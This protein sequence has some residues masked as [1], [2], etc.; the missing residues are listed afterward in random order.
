MI[1]RNPNQRV[2]VLVDVQNLH[3][4]AKN[5]FKAKISFEN[6]LKLAVRNRPLV[7]AIAYVIHSENAKENSF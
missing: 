3:Y 5:L 4:S 2:A 6:L 1:V 7:R